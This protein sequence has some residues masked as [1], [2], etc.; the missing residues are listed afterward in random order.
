MRYAPQVLSKAHSLTKICKNWF[1][2]RNS[3]KF[4]VISAQMTINANLWV[5]SPFRESYSVPEVNRTQTKR[6]ALLSRHRTAPPLN[7]VLFSVMSSDVSLQ[8]KWQLFYTPLDSPLGMGFTPI[9][10]EIN[11]KFVFITDFLFFLFELQDEFRRIILI[12]TSLLSWK[13]V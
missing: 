2:V 11:L 12:K 3:F 9:L 1:S 13:Q 5:S 10:I 6:I 7:R 8:M 4:L